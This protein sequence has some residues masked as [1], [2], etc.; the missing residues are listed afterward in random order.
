M[1]PC[2]AS[3]TICCCYCLSLGMMSCLGGALLSLLKSGLLSLSVFF[4]YMYMNNL[5]STHNHLPLTQLS[6]P[7]FSTRKFS[8]THMS[9]EPTTSVP[10]DR[11]AHRRGLFSE[12]TCFLAAGAATYPKIRLGSSQPSNN[13]RDIVALRGCAT[14]QSQQS[15]HPLYSRHLPSLQVLQRRE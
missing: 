3:K 4:T 15:K 8:A 5:A 2:S 14:S 6:E 1:L 12:R 7:L 10:R 9:F 11:L 13:S